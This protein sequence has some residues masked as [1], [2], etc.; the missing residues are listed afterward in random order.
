MLDLCRAEVPASPEERR[1][2]RI[3][4]GAQHGD[5][6]PHPALGEDAAV[7]PRT[8]ESRDFR[9]KGERREGPEQEREAL[10]PRASD[11]R[12]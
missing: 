6:S 9:R 5:R 3:V 10:G 11:H 2:S 4:V 8:I 7:E 12:D 1:Q